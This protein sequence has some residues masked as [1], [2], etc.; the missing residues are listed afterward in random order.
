MKIDENPERTANYA[1]RKLP[2]AWETSA[3]LYEVNEKN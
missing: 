3:D 2:R 1:K